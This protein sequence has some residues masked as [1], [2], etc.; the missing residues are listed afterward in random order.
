MFS[1]VTTLLILNSSMLR[2]RSSATLQSLLTIDEEMS[3]SLRHMSM[4]TR[5]VAP[6]LAAALTSS[7]NRT[8][9][10]FARLEALEN[11]HAGFETVQVD[12]DQGWRA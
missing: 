7:D 12:D 4:R 3:S 11:D 9:A 6:K 8:Q 10:M 5:M 2:H 1:Q